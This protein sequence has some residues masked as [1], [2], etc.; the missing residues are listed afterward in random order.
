MLDQVL[1]VFAIK[2]DY[3]LDLMTSAQT[4][5]SLTGAIIASVGKVIETCEP[6]IVVVHGDTTTSMATALTAFY[7]RVPVAHP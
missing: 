1:E 3:D 5:D 7:H 6:N 2:P 4:L